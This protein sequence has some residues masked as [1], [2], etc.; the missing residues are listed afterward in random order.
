MFCI[1]FEQIIDGHE[2]HESVL[3]DG[4]AA[5]RGIEGH[6]SRSHLDKCMYRVGIV[7]VEVGLMSSVVSK[8][9]KRCCDG[10]GEHCERT[11]GVIV[12]GWL[13]KL[14]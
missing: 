2:H 5:P 11:V 6:L 12:L 9:F 1:L 8:C 13:V 3:P 7:A 4:A 10:A 14:V